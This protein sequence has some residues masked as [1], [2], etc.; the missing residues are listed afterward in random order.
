[1]AGLSKLP[2]E[3][4]DELA[5]VQLDRMPWEEGKSPAA[6]GAKSNV[7]RQSSD[8]FTGN[9][10][11]YV[12]GGLDVP[13]NQAKYDSVGEQFKVLGISMGDIRTN[14][15]TNESGEPRTEFVP[16]P[17]EDRKTVTGDVIEGSGDLDEGASRMLAGGV[18]EAVKSTVEFGGWLLENTQADPNAKKAIKEA[19]DRFSESFP[20]MPAKDNS[21]KAVQEIVSTV[22][23]FAVGGMGAAKGVKN[24]DLAPKYMTFL[25]DFFKQ[26]SKKDPAAAK[27]KLDLLV[28]SLIVETSGN[29]GATAATAEGA[30][31]FSQDLG[32]MPDEIGG[33]E[34]TARYAGIFA[35]NTAFS[36]GMFTLGKLLGVPAGAIKKRLASPKNQAEIANKLLSTID[37][38]VTA[39]IPVNELARR[40]EILTDVVN[41]NKEFKFLMEGEAQNIPLDATSAIMMGAKEYMTR[42]NQDVMMN[43]P[44]DVAEE[45]ITKKAQAMVEQIMAIKQGL[46]AN[47]VVAA[48]DSNVLG[49]FGKAFE[50]TANNQATR[51]ESGQAAQTL[52]QPVADQL[53]TP[54]PD[55]L[56]SKEAA[57]NM[58][59]F[60]NDGELM[61][62]IQEARKSGVL[63]SNAQEKATLAG[64]TEEQLF[65]NYKTDKSKVDAMFAMVPQVLLDPTELAQAIQAAGDEK[66][67][68]QL[69]G[70]TPKEANLVNKVGADFVDAEGKTHSPVAEFAKVIEEN[71]LNNLNDLI[72]RIRPALAKQKNAIK[73]SGSR[74][75]KDTAQLDTVM[76]FME[77]SARESG[78]E[79]S[80]A[81]DNYRRF[82]DKWLN[83]QPLADFASAADSVRNVPLEN[84]DEVFQKGGPAMREAGQMAFVQSKDALSGEP[85]AKFVEALRTEG[86]TQ[87]KALSQALVGQALNQLSTLNPADAIKSSD[88]IGAV[89]PILQ[90]LE[91]LGDT[92]SVKLFNDT[93]E[94]LRLLESGV[95]KGTLDD[96]AAK[97]AYTLMQEKARKSAAID[98][99]FQSGELG[100]NK[101]VDAAG[102][103]EAFNKFFNKPNLPDRLDALLAQAGDDD[104][105][106]D[107]IKGE[108]LRWLKDR[109]TTTKSVGPTV[110]EEGLAF[111]KE[112]SGAQ[113]QNILEGRNGD[114]TLVALQ[115]AFKDDPETSGAVVQLM[116]VMDTFVNGRAAKAN[117]FGSNT[118]NDA[119]LA[120]NVNLLITLTLGVLNP[121]AT[122]ARGLAGMALEG[123]KENV[124]NA[125][126]ETLSKMV[127]N[128]EYLTT[129]LKMLADDRS[130]KT[131]I[132]F[133]NKTGGV[134]MLRGTIGTNRP[135]VD[136]QTE[137]AIPTQ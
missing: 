88:I 84:S 43:M 119:Q 123:N 38:G 53:N 18:L 69:L 87:D 29:I 71:G 118:V 125:V 52:G 26:A 77:D 39:D 47:P 33:S 82:A 70:L 90:S 35:D 131:F 23:G 41:K 37:E 116:Q 64:L 107:G 101:P 62:Q 110:G 111:S 126:N 65:N 132:N 73:S 117:P 89:Q 20:T 54:V 36:A 129:S 76:E 34:E 79:F 1:M 55:N 19:K 16:K 80:E 61:K 24:I 100:G 134:N 93:V 75:N 81:M 3:Q 122:K 8:S 59:N 30:G 14:Q 22:A 44:P 120:R 108:M 105:V 112:A 51:E 104:L 57:A 96:N 67:I 17:R 94:Q 121:V 4:Q 114:N 32:L 63:G 133:F 60:Q 95:A 45:V 85:L 78:P 109:I 6:L 28:R 9:E 113:L 40:T 74:I 127:T 72:N 27:A 11:D 103:N 2:W 13:E 21:E 130:G 83:T 106:K 99:V 10:T 66:G 25:V 115:K 49:G 50:N 7:V 86:G 15:V 91:R 46:K 92:E 48:S 135:T 12:P 31:S 98:F 5:P 97:A 124:R 136:D 128:P 102:A 42:V 137:E 58:A 56:A 68:M